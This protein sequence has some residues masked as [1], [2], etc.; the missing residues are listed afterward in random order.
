M[1]KLSMVKLGMVVLMLVA[2]SL[3]AAPVLAQDHGTIGPRGHHMMGDGPGMM[4]PLVLKKLN[5]LDERVSSLHTA[6]PLEESPE[7]VR[8]TH[9]WCAAICGRAANDLSD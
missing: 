6:T 7:G 4:L 9:R 5:L 8:T 2:L 3:W 1:K